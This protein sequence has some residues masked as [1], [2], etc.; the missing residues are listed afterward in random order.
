MAKNYIVIDVE[1]TGLHPG[2]AQIIEVGAIKVDKDMKII[3]TYES[4]VNCQ[5]V[6]PFITNLTGIETVMVKDAP[7]A[8]KVMSE[9]SEFASDAVPIAHNS[10]FDKKFIRFHLED[11]NTEYIETEWIDTLPIFRREFIDVEN[12]KLDTLIRAF[13]LA[14]K[15]D[16]RALSDAK[17]TLTLLKKAGM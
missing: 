6:P 14:D 10:P 3:D 13:G 8:S 9:L 1:T 5:Y 17:H 2:K 4:F 16:H 11:T 7:S 12:H 15:E